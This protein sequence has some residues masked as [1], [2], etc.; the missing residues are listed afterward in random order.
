MRAEQVVDAAVVAQNGGLSVH[1]RTG[2]VVAEVEVPSIGL[3]AVHE[4]GRVVTEYRTYRDVAPSID[5]KGGV[6]RGIVRSVE[7]APRN[8]GRTADE[9]ALAAA[10]DRHMNLVVAHRESVGLV[11]HFHLDSHASQALPQLE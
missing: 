10:V 3:A 8:V 6:V 7:A 1:G 11:L 5:P 9:T 2:Y 4:T